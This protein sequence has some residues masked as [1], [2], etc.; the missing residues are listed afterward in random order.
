MQYLFQFFNFI[1]REASNAVKQEKIY[2]L[3]VKQA[4]QTQWSNT[5]TS[6]AWRDADL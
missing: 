1:W 4:T 5:V 2:L 3:N 6:R